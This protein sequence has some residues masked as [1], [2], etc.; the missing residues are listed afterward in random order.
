MRVPKLELPPEL[1][2]TDL[3][4]PEILCIIYDYSAS[5]ELYERKK[6]MHVELSWSLKRYR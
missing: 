1:L 4:P 3:L 6:E 2:Y 5:M